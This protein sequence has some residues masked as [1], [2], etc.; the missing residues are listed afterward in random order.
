VNGKAHNSKD[1]FGGSDVC[2]VPVVSYVMLGG[3]KETQEKPRSESSVTQLCG[4]SI[5][6]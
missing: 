1:V 6:C 2:E 5:Q 4:V 3:T